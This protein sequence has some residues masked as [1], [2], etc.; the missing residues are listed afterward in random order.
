MRPEI[1]ELKHGISKKREVEIQEEEF[2]QRFQQLE[3]E[4]SSL[5]R[6]RDELQENLRC[7]EE[8]KDEMKKILQENTEVVRYNLFNNYCRLYVAQGD[9]KE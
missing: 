1:E 7:I 3:N 6:E 5:I 2:N 8:E 9:G 4:K